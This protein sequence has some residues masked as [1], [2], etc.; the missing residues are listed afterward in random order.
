MYLLGVDGGGTKTHCVVGDEKGNIFAEGFGGP[1]N[2]DCVG[3]E[4][5]KQSIHTA[6][7]RALDKLN[8]GIQDI[9]CAVLGLAGADYPEDYE[10]LGE[11]CQ[12]IFGEVP[13]E[14]VNDCLIALRAGSENGWG[15]VSI[16]GT[17]HGA[18]GVTKEGRRI[19][20]R[21]MDYDLGNRGGG[22]E[23]LREAMHHA[24]RADEGIS[25]ST[26]LQ[27]E[28][29]KVFKVDSM[30][31]VDRIIRQRGFDDEVKYRIPVVVA[32]LAK[33][34]DKVAQNIM[35]SMG[36]ALG[37]TAAGIIRRMGAMDDEVTMVLAGSVFGGD[38]P[39][40]IDMYI[41]EVHKVAP[42]AKVKIL[43]KKPVMG[44]YYLAQDKTK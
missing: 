28:I 15:V 25:A 1:A 2:Y 10:I 7:M 32:Q 23:L 14:V 11:M 18:M 12:E 22:G 30:V 13:F 35:M 20:L 4:T 31:E 34:R 6:I 33:E 44:A 27:H 21:N 39:L 43:D 37:Q 19:E 26:K 40:L 38:N 8:I 5:T 16:C 29:P 17:G 3:I 24:F 42:W 41:L 36:K 9:E